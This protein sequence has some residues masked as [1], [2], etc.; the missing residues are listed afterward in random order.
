MTFLDAISAAVWSSQVSGSFNVC[1]PISENTL[2]WGF[3]CW[4][5]RLEIDDLF[6]YLSSSVSIFYLSFVI[7]LFILL[8]K[9][10]TNL[11]ALHFIPYNTIQK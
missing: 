2:E 4:V 6:S 10:P 7:F 5:Q 11:C 9:R 8:P 3:G 1:K